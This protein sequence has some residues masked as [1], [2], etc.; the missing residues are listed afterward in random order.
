MKDMD[1]IKRIVIYYRDLPESLIK[2]VALDSNMTFVKDGSYMCDAIGKKAPR[3]SITIKSSKEKNP[4]IDKKRLDLLI[5][6]VTVLERSG[7]IISYN[8]I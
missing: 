1:I 8:I 7:Q 2:F 6:E 4:L 3:L 5:Q